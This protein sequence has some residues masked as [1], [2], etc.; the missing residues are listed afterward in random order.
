MNTKTMLE[1]FWEK[2][3]KT[4]SCWV[5]TGTS[6]GKD[7]YGRL[8]KPN[9]KHKMQVHRYSW[10]LHKGPIPP[11]MCVLHKCDTPACVNPA[12][13]MLGTNADNSADMVSKRRQAFGLKNANGKV[14]W[15]RVLSIR[16]MYLRLSSTIIGRIAKAHRVSYGYVW[17]IVSKRS[18]TLG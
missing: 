3:E 14:R 9:S 4:N 5:W 1:R 18:R 7:G 15:K 10:Q 16:R 17:E 13:L 8:R 2:V 6:D 11:G 12:H